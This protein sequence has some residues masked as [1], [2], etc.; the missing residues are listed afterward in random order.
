MMHVEHD[1]E[2]NSMGAHVVFSEIRPLMVVF[3]NKMQIR[4]HEYRCNITGRGAVG[5]NRGYH[6]GIPPL[7]PVDSWE[8]LQPLYNPPKDKWLQIMDF[9]H[10]NFLLFSPLS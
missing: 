7:Y 10:A 8:W 3:M 1:P 4:V 9:L 5:I 6:T 2:C